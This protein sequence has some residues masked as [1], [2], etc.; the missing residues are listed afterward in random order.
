MHHRHP[1]HHGPHIRPPHRGPHM[2]MRRPFLPSMIFL[3][4]GVLLFIKLMPLLLMLA[5]PLLIFGGIKAATCTT[6]WDHQS[7]PG[8]RKNDGSGPEDD[9]F[10]GDDRDDDSDESPR[11]IIV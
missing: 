1:M 3:F 7:T 9:P 10:Y 8:K 6:R 11:V 5:V 2:S 4:V